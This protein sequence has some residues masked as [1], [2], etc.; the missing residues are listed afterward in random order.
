MSEA[1]LVQT[2]SDQTRLEGN[3]SDNPNYFALWI[4]LWILGEKYRD[5]QSD[6]RQVPQLLWE[7][8]QMLYKRMA[9]KAIDKKVEYQNNQ[10][11]HG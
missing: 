7:A 4:E 10:T 3:A 1:V 9:I 8:D 2:K 11:K 6:G 5:H